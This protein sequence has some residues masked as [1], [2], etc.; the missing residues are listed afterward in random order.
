MGVAQEYRGNL[1]AIKKEVAKVVVGQ[2]GVVDGFLR[3]ILSNGHVLVEGVPG[4]AKTLLVRALA[5][6]TGCSFSRI[7]FTVDLLPA[8]ITGITTFDKEKGFEIIK[9]PIFANFV[10]AD[11]VNR[12]PPKTQSALLEAMQERQTTIG[13]KTFPMPEPFF[14]MATQNPIESGGT[15]KLPEA[16]V[17]RFLFKIMMGYPGEEEERQI[18]KT[19][20]TL[21]RFEEHDLGA[22]S[23]PKILTT[24]QDHTK[25]V[26]MTEK[27]ERYIVQIVAA[28]RNPKEL[29]LKAGKYIEYGCSPRASI[30]LFI[31]AKADA[32]LHGNEFVT[33]QNVKNVAY[34]VLRHRL[35]LNYEG[36]AEGI[37]GEQ[38]IEEL[39][40][41][42]KVP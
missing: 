37:T 39:L 16:Q 15:Y 36:Q 42:I 21:Y 30:G 28:T 32:V 27:I 33:P 4:I 3:G 8:D 29:N 12:A 7:Q 34:D 26:F 6:A 18:L 13:R 5:M 40:G 20:M 9:G 24:M 22:A 38:V 1:E 14:V 17:D 19:N 35:I 2:S 31:A 11:E 23:N 25:K 41:K 10:I